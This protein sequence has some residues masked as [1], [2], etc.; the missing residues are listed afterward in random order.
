[1]VDPETAPTLGEVSLDVNV[2]LKLARKRGTP[3]RYA[4]DTH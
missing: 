3:S 1:M 4:E 2:S